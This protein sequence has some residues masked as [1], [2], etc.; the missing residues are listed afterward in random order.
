LVNGPSILGQLD[1][2]RGGVTGYQKAGA[3][4]HQLIGRI[5]LLEVATAAAIFQRLPV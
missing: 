1:K 2:T 3:E 4:D 5:N